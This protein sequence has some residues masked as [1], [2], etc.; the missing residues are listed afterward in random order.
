MRKEIIIVT[1]L[2]ISVLTL[3]IFCQKYLDRVTGEMINSLKEIKEVS[4]QSLE[5]D[6]QKQK[7]I[8]HIKHMDE[9]WKY[10][11]GK[12]SLYIE[13][14]ELEKVDA[15]FVRM[16]SKLEI[17][18]YAEAI[19]EIDECIFMFEHIDEKQKISLKNLF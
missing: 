17:D 15:C 14:S 11:E 10:Y 5:K 7:I 8:E 3:I 12:L 9:K 1:G 19:P 16:R 18:Q 2:L 13:H 4:L 6:Y